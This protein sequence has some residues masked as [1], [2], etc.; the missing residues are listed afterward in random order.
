M[1][2]I[3]KKVLIMIH[4]LQENYAEMKTLI[5]TASMNLY[6][7]IYMYVCMYLCNTPSARLSAWLWPAGL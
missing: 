4:N 7:L 5:Y 1:N 2:L 6:A 3:W